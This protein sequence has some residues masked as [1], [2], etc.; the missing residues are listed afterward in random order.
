MKTILSLTTALA[1]LLCM[2]TAA[3]A[4]PI[5][6]AGRFG[7]GLGSG[8]IANGLSLKYFMAD[9]L[10]IQANV[11]VFGGRG[12]DRLKDN[13][14]IAASAD[15]LIENSPL[16]ASSLLNLEWN[17]GVGAGIGVRNDNS[18][19]AAAGVLGLEVNFNV[20]PVD[21]VFEYRPNLALSPDVDLDF[22]DFSGHIRYYFQ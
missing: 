10:A 3:D 7:I 19:I 2:S 12:R 13:G 22:V 6:S 11:G 1:A 20:I 16:I 17:Y 5:H 9:S 8:T 15:I 18:A 21:I 4:K 14:G